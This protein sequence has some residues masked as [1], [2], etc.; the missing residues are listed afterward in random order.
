MN[1]SVLGFRRMT[2]DD[3]PLMYRWLQTSD[4]LEWWF[5]GVAPAYETVAETY[6]PRIRGE[7]PTD[8]YLI[9]YT[10]LPIGYIQT[11]MIR[12]YPEY[13]AV[14]DVEE[15][16]AGVDLFIGEA[17]YL[18]RGLGSH[19]LRAFLREI[20]FAGGAD[21]CV[22]GP[23]VKNAIAIRAYEKAGF[24]HFKTVTVGDEPEPEYLMRIARG[25]LTDPRAS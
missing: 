6:G 25:D 14:V 2:M 16:A 17:E 15:G 18:H 8:S 23:S 5:G 21:R 12:D 20:V 11:Y 22:I 24:R 1:P 13:A 9:L 3:L 19:I 10:D 4:V 7:E